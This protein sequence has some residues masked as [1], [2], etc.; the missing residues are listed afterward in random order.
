MKN[1]LNLLAIGFIGSAYGIEGDFISV[2]SLPSQSCLVLASVGDQPL[3][4]CS[5]TIVGERQVLTAAHCLGLG[6][7]TMTHDEFKLEVFCPQEKGKRV[8]DISIHPA[9]D[10][11]TM[12]NDHAVLI[13]EADFTETSPISIPENQSQVE[14]LLERRDCIVTGYGQTRLENCLEH[15]DVCQEVQG[16]AHLGVRLEEVDA[17]DL[18]FPE[19]IFGEPRTDEIRIGPDNTIGA[20]DSG[21]GAY[22]RSES[23]ENIRIASN[24]AGVTTVGFLSTLTMEDPWAQFAIQGFSEE[25]DT[26][27][28]LSSSCRGLN[29]CA[30]YLKDLTDFINDVD[31]IVEALNTVMLERISEEE[32]STAAE[33]ANIR[34]ENFE[35]MNELNLVCMN[36]LKPVYDGLEKPNTPF[37]GSYCAYSPSSILSF[38]ENGQSYSYEIG[39]RNDVILE[40]LEMTDDGRPMGNLYIQCSDFIPEANEYCGVR[41]DVEISTSRFMLSA[42]FRQCSGPGPN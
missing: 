30:N 37:A 14:S 24:T 10:P 26:V 4:K 33:L 7:S 38:R 42:I 32:E 2:E 19:L 12:E 5:G 29:G 20:G 25:L 11:I 28:L 23:G 6:M 21:G 15:Q 40:V 27:S 13:V 3:S 39:D 17:E 22:C 41:R 18:V 36:I 9:Y 34:F 8:E 16:M 35:V 31:S 1:L